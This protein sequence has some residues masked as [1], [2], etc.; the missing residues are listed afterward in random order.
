MLSRCLAWSLTGEGMNNTLLTVSETAR[1]LSVSRATLYRHWDRWGLTP[2]RLD[3]NLR[4]SA[5]DVEAFI[6]SLRA[7]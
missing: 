7:A 2:S 3:G 6:N 4:F 1:R 5:A